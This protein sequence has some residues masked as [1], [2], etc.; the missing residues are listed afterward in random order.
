[1]T[2]ETRT[3]SPA[4][5]PVARVEPRSRA[6]L[7][8]L[9][10][11]LALLAVA[12]LVIQQWRDRGPLIEI[13]VPR[14]SGL[15]SGRTPVYSQGVRIGV[16]ED[17]RLDDDLK[18]P[19]L[20]VR[21]HRWASTFARD[22]SSYWIVRPSIGFRGVSGLETLTSGPVLE[23][24][25]G[26]PD[27]RWISRFEALPRPPADASSTSGLHLTLTAARLG[28]VRPG[29]A[30]TY[31]DIEVGEVADTRLSGDA[32]FAL[33]EIVVYDRYAPLIRESTRFWNTSGFGMDLGVTGLKLRTESIESILG[34]GI[35]FATP[36]ATDPPAKDGATFEL[37]TEPEK[38]WLR[39]TPAIELAK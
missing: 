2:D 17:V 21:L 18:H 8:W 14:A 28:S 38:D 23:A 12:I 5:M 24:R 37:A 6:R 33:I 10:P 11:L 36:S 32:K 9:V 25:P 27:A 1:M 20:A 29:S 22:G 7:M 26:S 19:V 34:G 15:E 4:E 3:E 35:A 31:R 13:V 16:V 30:V 39:W